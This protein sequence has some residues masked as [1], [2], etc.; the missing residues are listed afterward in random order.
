MPFPSSKLSPRSG[1]TRRFL[2]NQQL[3]IVVAIALFALV[4]VTNWRNAD[5]VSILLFSLFVANLTMSAMS[6]LAPFSSQLRF[7]YNWLVYL[8][9][10]S[11]VALASATSGVVLI[12]AVFRL[13][14]ASFP[15]LFW[16]AGRLGVLVILIVGIIYHLY[17]DTRAK[18]ER[19]NLEL[20]HTVEIGKTQSQLQ[21]QELDKAR[22]IQE[23]LLP[24]KIPQVRGLEVAGAWQP[25]RVVGGD[26]F[27]V[28][29]FSER[30]IGLCIGDVVGKGI[31]AALLMANLQATFRAFASES[32]SAAALCPK[33]NGV[34]FNNIAPDKFITFCYCMIDAAECRLNY[35]NAG[36]WP[37]ILLHRSGTAVFL[38]QGGAPLGIFPDRN[39]EDAEARLEPGDRLVLYTDGVTEATNSEGQEFGEPKLVELGSRN[40]AL[41]ASDLL[42][43]I[44]KE[45]ASFSAG[46][47]QDDFTLV[48]VAV[49]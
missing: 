30:K 9:F 46:S 19:R 6:R 35:A 40:V 47:F 1:F 20:Q 17:S 7:P 12:M 31:T 25:A 36:H 22:E 29:K 38:K 42:E 2:R 34:L 37:P 18:L 21:E 41:S 45:V 8:S 13:P 10:L 26:Y 33:L 3:F 11:L 43:T 32:V 15:S 48:V 16:S 5:F 49:K 4:W 23:G 44:M 27:D 39:Y 14:L 24:K 28:L